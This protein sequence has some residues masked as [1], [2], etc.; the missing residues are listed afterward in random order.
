M[1][2]L[3]LHNEFRQP[4]ASEDI[5][6]EITVKTCTRG[7]LI[8]LAIFLAK[9]FPA[10]ALHDVNDPPIVVLNDFASSGKSMFI[11]AMMK[12]LLDQTDPRDMLK[13][14]AP[15]RMFIEKNPM[16]ALNSYCFA[17]GTHEGVSVLYGFDRINYWHKKNL[18]RQFKEAAAGVNPAPAGG[19]IFCSNGV[20]YPD[21]GEWLDIGLYS[22]PN[23]RGWGKT[24]AIAVKDE[25]LKADPKFRLYW[26][27]LQEIV[28]AGRFAQLEAPVGR[29]FPKLGRPKQP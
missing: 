22:S 7:E 10:A 4:A 28:K 9:A 1:T 3:N 26:T 15:R 14:K 17:T 24:T 6:W 21:T 2:Q 25:R 8:R 12:T 5:P 18:Q 19:A 16:Q 23:E 27:R 11:E 13:P 20:L 29:A